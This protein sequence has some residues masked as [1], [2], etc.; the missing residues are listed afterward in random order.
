MKMSGIIQ[1][2]QT[3]IK[4][5]SPEILT[6]I[7]IAG[8]ITSTVLAVRATPKAM[9]LIDEKR[10]KIDKPLWRIYLE[11][12]WKCYIPAGA[13][14]ILS[15]ACIIGGQKESLRRNTALATAYSISENALKLYQ[16]KV[17]ETIG[18]K[19][20]QL[21][22]DAVVKEHIKNN[23]INTREII[24]TEKGNTRIYEP[25]TNQ[26]VK[27][28][29]NAVKKIENELNSRIISDMYITLNDFYYELG[30]KPSSI[31]DRIGWTID[32]RLKFNFS[33]QIADDDQPVIVIDYI[34][35]PEYLF[36]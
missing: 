21:V 34:N 13:T 14:G 35:Q 1:N 31:G 10:G 19:K 9:E 16:R 30:I 22:R 32:N 25:I 15:I 18:E 28:D 29:I 17:I 12:G 20:E 2:I 23:P 27:S 8:M 3:T 33:A 24:V 6:G 36:N 26:C 5:H 7:G 4:K 11:N